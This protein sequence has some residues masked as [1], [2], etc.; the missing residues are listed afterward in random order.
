LEQ[1]VGQHHRRAQVAKKVAHTSAEELRGG[2]AVHARRRLEQQ[3]VD[4]PVELKDAPVERLQGIILLLLGKRRR[5]EQSERDNRATQ[6]GQPRPPGGRPGHGARR[7][8][9]TGLLPHLVAAPS[10]SNDRQTDRGA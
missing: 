3:A 8:R 10:G 5:R 2:H 6:P 9:Q 1:V 4:D 7:S